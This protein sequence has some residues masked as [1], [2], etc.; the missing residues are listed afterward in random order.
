MSLP[1]KYNHVWVNEIL[2]RYKQDNNHGKNSRALRVLFPP[3]K[4]IK[5]HAVRSRGKHK[6]VYLEI[7]AG[8]DIETTTTEDHHGYMYI[9]Q[10]CINQ[11]VIL[12]SE[13]SEFTELL[14]IM[15]QYLK[16]SKEYRLIIWVANLSFEFQFM[17]KWLLIES[18]FA[19]EKRQPLQVLCTNGIEF[20]EAL[21]IS[22]MGGLAQLAKEY[23]T[24]QKLVGDLDYNIARNKTD[25]KNLTPTELQY[26]LN[27][28]IILKEFSEYI[29]KEFIIKQRFVPLTSTQIIRR[30]VQ[31]LAPKDIHKAIVPCFFP[32]EDE[33]HLYMMYLFRGGYVHANYKYANK[34]LEN[35]LHI[36]I[37]SSYP[38]EMY[39]SY[40]PVS[41]FIESQLDPRDAIQKYCCIIDVTFNNLNPLTD[42]SI[43]SI[44]KVLEISGKIIDNGRVRHANSMRVLLTELDFKIYQLYYSWDSLEVHS[45]KIARR[46]KMPRYIMAALTP[47]YEIKESYSRKGLKDTIEYKKSKPFVNGFYGMTVS[48]MHP[49]EIKYDEEEG[50]TDELNEKF[51]YEKEKDKAFLLPQFGIWITAAARHKLLSVLYRC[52]QVYYGDT[53]SLFMAECQHNRKVLDQINSEQIKRNKQAIKHYGLSKYFLTIGTWDIEAEHI[54]RFK[55]L[56][57]KRYIEDINGKLSVTIAGLPKNALVDYCQENH[58]DLFEIFRN[59]M[60]LDVVVSKKLAHTYNDKPHAEVVNG[61]LMV[62]RSS[63]GIY[64]TTFQLTLAEEYLNLMR[65]IKE[66]E[67]HGEARIY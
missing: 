2:D 51:S 66:V 64:K 14:N 19:K 40:V 3:L 37:K 13:W 60:F 39:N 32:S 44:N 33:Y 55:T 34:T 15:A 24:T 9:W 18:I 29:F 36:D 43:E 50:W 56:G 22:G 47:Y 10:M 41:P 52:R 26:C 59:K 27:D 21:S 54:N 7:F 31:D 30:K 35:V 62:E 49:T 45:L 57:A 38:D 48:R 6:Q 5:K 25:G 67:H 53:D 11:T 16:L 42:H 46:G 23:C 58:L 65:K 1:A 8:F 20:R 12:G 28:V 4:E 63:V 61:E 17:R